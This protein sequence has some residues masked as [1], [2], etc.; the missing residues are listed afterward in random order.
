MTEDGD[1]GGEVIGSRSVV[2][3]AEG[4]DI[5]DNSG[6]SALESLGYGVDGSSDRAT[7]S[8]ETSTMDTIKYLLPLFVVVGVLC[9]FVVVWLV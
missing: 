2:D 4:P 9:L 6:S 7:G 3:E 8:S 1:G 5:R